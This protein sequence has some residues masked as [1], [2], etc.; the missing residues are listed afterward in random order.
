MDRFPIRMKNDLSFSECKTPDTAL[1]YLGDEIIVVD[2]Q[3]EQITIAD[4]GLFGS[5]INTFAANNR[6]YGQLLA[7]EG[8]TWEFTLLEKHPPD[9]KPFP[10][11]GEHDSRAVLTL[12]DGRYHLHAYGTDDLSMMRGTLSNCRGWIFDA[13]EAS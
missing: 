9:A 1:H 4:T 10:V 13:E 5:P 6:I 7:H 3:G 12:K 11:L 2:V 8:D